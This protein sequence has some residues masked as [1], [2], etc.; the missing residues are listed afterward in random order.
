M[1]CVLKKRRDFLSIAQRGIFVKGRG[2]LVQICPVRGIGS[3]QVPLFF[4]ITASKK[5]GNAVCRNRAKRRLRAWVR[6]NL[7]SILAV[8]S[9]K[10]SNT[11][12]EFPYLSKRTLTL[13]TNE[14]QMENF[15]SLACVFIA[16]KATVNISWNELSQECQRIVQLGIRQLKL[17]FSNS[18]IFKF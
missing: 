12:D 11:S 7:Q 5:V 17:N 13:L 6:G 2:C 16:T 10:F 1:L 18:A 9:L 4:G 3:G 15:C 8:S 14:G